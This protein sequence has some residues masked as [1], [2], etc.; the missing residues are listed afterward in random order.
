MLEREAIGSR[1]PFAGVKV[2]AGEASSNLQF[3][4][5]GHWKIRDRLSPNNNN[6]MRSY[7][8]FVAQPIIPGEKSTP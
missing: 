2:H 1:L 7:V 6:V 8:D 4:D 5:I 3:G